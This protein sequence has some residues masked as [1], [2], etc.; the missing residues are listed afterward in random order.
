MK[1]LLLLFSMMVC[2]SITVY[3]QKDTVYVPGFYESG[4]TAE[5]YGTLNT[6]IETARANGTINNTVFKLTSY[7]VYVLSRSIFMSFG[8]NLEIVA[9]KPLRDGEG[10]PEEVQASAPP[11]IV[12]TEEEIDRTYIIQTYGD[13]IMKNIWI[14]FDDFSSS[15]ASGSQ[16]TTSIAFEDS[17]EIQ[18]DDREMGYFEGCVF[19]YSR[20]GAEGSGSIC[21]KVDHFTG[22]FKDC[23]FRNISDFH[24]Q[25][26]GRAVS[27]PFDQTGFHYDSLLFENCTFTNLG[28]IVM[29]EAQ[30]YG[31]NVHLNH[32]TMVNSVEWVY[33]TGRFTN[34]GWLRHCSITNSIFV[35]PWMF[36]YR[37]LDVCE[38][39][40]DYDDFE[41]GLCDPPGNG[42]LIS[43][44]QPVDSFGF[45]V[46]WTDFDRKLY[47]GNIAYMYQDWLLAYY[48][49]CTWCRQQIQQRH[50]EELYNPNPM[51][52]ED[53]VAFIDSVDTEGNKV[54]PNLNVDWTTVYGDDPEF[55]E[56]P[57]NI[58][59]LK[60]FL[61]GRWG[62]GLDIDW[63]YV[64]DATFAQSWPL[65]EKLAYNNAAYQTASMGGFPLGDLNWFPDQKTAWEAQRESEW[66]V[67]KNWLNFGTGDPG[68]VKEIPGAVP[69]KYVLNQNYPNPF[70]PSTNIEYSIPKSGYVSLKVFNLLGQEVA[71]I[72]EGPQQAGN[73]VATFHSLG[74]SSGVYMY[75]LQAGDVSIAKKFI[76]EK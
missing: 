37:A 14:R 53:D 20:I 24:Y 66:V 26:Y 68:A 71:T 11:Q 44:I 51:L 62:T 65:P 61:E 48:N 42:G 23:F 56:N 74:L 70:N 75:R 45:T 35:N 63:A 64:K 21:V 40:Q 7:D 49:E 12:W 3:A 25:Y 16:R 39:D 1:H 58:D 19:D 47:V 10:T 5:D 57:T 17:I 27:F 67:I 52:S 2:L 60:L 30:S 76:L 9:D 34:E 33:Q 41:D 43:Q 22:I 8:E 6:A 18:G 69:V 50:P 38:D 28:R 32:C 54:F 46:D 13:V 55:I 72:F 15:S 73:Y 31:D 59:T 4:G 29:Q 36:G